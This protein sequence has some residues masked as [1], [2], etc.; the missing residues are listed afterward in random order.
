TA[1]QHFLRRL[2]PQAD[3]R[4]G[5]AAE[6]AVVVVAHGDVGLEALDDRNVHFA[7]HRPQGARVV[8]VLQVAAVTGDVAGGEQRVRI[9]RQRLLVR[10]KAQ[11]ESGRSGRQ[12]E[13]VT[14]A[15]EVDAVLLQMRRKRTI[16]ELGGINLLL[17]GLRIRSEQVDVAAVQDRQDLRI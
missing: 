1:D 3:L 4:I 16:G 6:V 14:G 12:L 8:D 11:G 9:L 7:E 2:P 10:L 15:L 17:N 13:N 5:R